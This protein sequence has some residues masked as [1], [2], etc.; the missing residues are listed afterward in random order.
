MTDNLIPDA[1]YQVFATLSEY[2]LAVDTVI[3]SAQAN[4][5]VFDTDLVDMA[6]DDSARCELL[7]TFL[8]QGSAKRLHIVLRDVLFLQQRAARMQRLLRDFSQQVEIRQLAEARETDAFIYSDAGVCL[9][10]PQHDHAKS[11][12]THHDH[13][14]CRLFSSRFALMFEAAEQAVSATI[15]GL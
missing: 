4:L 9:Y 13:A 10:R 7:R 8:A 12:L 6:L 14:R 1:G 11:I 2:R 3:L 15:L 5:N